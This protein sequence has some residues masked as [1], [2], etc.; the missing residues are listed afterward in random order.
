MQ[1]PKPV[2]SSGGAG[3]QIGTENF[4]RLKDRQEVKAVFRGDVLV[5][6]Q[7][8]PKGGRKEVFTTP[9]PGAKPRYLI[10]AVVHDGTKFVAKVFEMNPPTYEMFF[11]IAEHIPVDKTK[12]LV[13][14]I[15]SDTNTKYS[16]IALAHEPLSAQHLA[17]IEAVKLNVLSVPGANEGPKA[18]E[19]ANEIAG[20]SD[21]GSVPF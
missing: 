8:W 5:I 2:P 12:I 20:G 13:A 6:Y 3:L 15:G 1:L 18:G 14:R 11:K 10:N 21:D 17:E 7:R 16:L 4:L 9:E 19:F